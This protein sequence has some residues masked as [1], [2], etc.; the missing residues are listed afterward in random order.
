MLLSDV[1]TKNDEAVAGTDYTPLIHAEVTLSPG[2]R[3]A[4]LSV[5]IEDD[6]ILEPSEDF[7]VCWSPTK[8]D[9]LDDVKCLQVVTIVD[10]DSR[11]H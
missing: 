2:V 9:D 11:L 6:E 8:V 7:L 1:Y 10:D 4:S 5:A 3:S